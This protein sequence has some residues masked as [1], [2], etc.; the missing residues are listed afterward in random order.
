MAVRATMANL[1]TR[2][3]LLINDPSGASQIFDD[4]SIHNVLDDSRQDISNTAL[5]PYVTFSGGTIMYL[6]YYH[7]LGSWEDNVTLKQYLTLL[8]TPSA[9]E[10]I[11]GHW[12]FAASTL[13]PVYITGSTHDIYRAAADLLERWAARL[14]LEFDFTSDGQSFHRSQASVALQKLAQTYRKKQ[15]PTTLAM[16]RD[17]ISGGK[18]DMLGLGPHEVDYMAKE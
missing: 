17:D 10:P 11:A 1:I 16:V 5:T 7:T 15:R 9:S 14:V 12:Q 4:Q 3:R 13:P 8:V 6:D 2:V 18:R